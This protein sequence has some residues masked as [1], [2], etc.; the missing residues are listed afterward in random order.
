MDETIQNAVDDALES[1]DE[2]QSSFFQA[3]EENLRKIMEETSRAPKD[4]MEHWSAFTSAIN[5]RESLIVGILVFHAVMLVLVLTT[6]K[7]FGFQVFVFLFACLLV[8]TSEHINTAASLHWKSFATQNYF[9]KQGVFMGIFFNAPLLIIL[10]V[11]MVRTFRYGKSLFFVLF[12]NLYSNNTAQFLIHG[13]F[14]S[15]QGKEAST[16]EAT[17]RKREKRQKK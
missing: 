16:E 5:W 17:S 6:R 12:T 7:S 4:L 15:Y 10:F 13:K 11:Q 8:Y 2:S 14:R 9:D 1:A 3:V